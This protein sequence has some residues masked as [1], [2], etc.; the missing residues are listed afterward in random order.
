MKERKVIYNVL[1]SVSVI[2][3][4]IV[5]RPKVY[6]KE[7]IP[8][9]GAIILAGNHKHALDPIVVV[10]GT[11]RFVHFMAK[12]EVSGGL[13]GKIFDLV[14]I[15]RV[16]RD[17]SKNIASVLE[18]EDMLKS[19]GT[20]GIFPEGTRNRTD[21][22]L[23]KFRIGTVS[24]ATKTET[25][26]VPFAIRGNYRIFRK[27]LEIEFGKPVDVGKMEIQ[28]ANDYLKDEVLKLLTKEN[29]YEG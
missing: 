9:T 27:G 3:L 12:E 24:M 29:L 15:I 2:L 11:K 1:K 10:S 18:A 17:K 4:K 6:G 21:K 14:G 23:L 25:Q 19:G 7:N 13:H 26:I 16:Y 8:K 28:E 5:F 22:P 20:L